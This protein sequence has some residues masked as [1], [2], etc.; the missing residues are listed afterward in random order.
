VRAYAVFVLLGFLAAWAVRRGE[1]GRLGHREMPGYH[2]VS[3]GALLGAAVGAKLGMVLFEPIANLPALL[4]RM[5]DLDFT[6][7]T[8][9]GGL[10]GGYLGVELAKKAAG[11]TRSTGD[12]FAVALPVAQG[13]GRLGCLFNGCCFGAPWGGAWAV[14]TAGAL[15]HPAQ[16]Y[17]TVLDLGLAALLWRLRGRGYPAGNLFKRY[18]VGYATVRFVTEFFRGD[19]AIWW[20]PLKAVQWVCLAAALGFVAVLWRSERA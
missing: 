14:Q 17:E 18:L 1:V 2:W 11:I 6:G 12:G 16:L 19:P 8:V 20:G 9:V 5:A 13:I 15:R 4:A 7:K 3:A 10:A